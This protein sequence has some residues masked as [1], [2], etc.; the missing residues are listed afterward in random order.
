MWANTP[1]SRQDCLGSNAE[2]LL[3]VFIP[4]THQDQDQAHRPAQS[5]RDTET[6]GPSEDTDQKGESQV[7]AVVHKDRHH[8]MKVHREGKNAQ[9]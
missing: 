6:T 4:S 8:D 3:E 5:T 1:L 2:N 9:W 7:T